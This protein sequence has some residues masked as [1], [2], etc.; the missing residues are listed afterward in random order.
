MPVD[1]FSAL[2]DP[3]RRRILEMLADHDGL[4]ASEI[5]DQ[6]QVSPQAISQHLKMLRG[7]NLVEVE[8][9][10]Q[11]RIYRIN[12]KAMVQFEEWSKR[13][14]QRWSRRLDTLDAVL[15]EEM[16]KHANNQIE[17]EKP[18]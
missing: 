10:A 5:Y 2:A 3:T 7:A 6:F 16:K 11:Q 14:R 12:T 8:K 15:K 9:R 1:I 4:S 13:M 17:K 18:E